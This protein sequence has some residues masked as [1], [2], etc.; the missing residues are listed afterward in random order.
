MSASGNF[1]VL[2]GV[3]SRSGLEYAAALEVPLDAGGLICSQW[4]LTER[5]DLEPLAGLL[6]QRLLDYSASATAI[7]GRARRRCSLNRDRQPRY[8][9]PNWGCW[10]R[11]SQA[12]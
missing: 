4:L 2:A 9:S 1:R 6:L 7:S 5:F 10:R 12:G 8:G 11:T 3:G